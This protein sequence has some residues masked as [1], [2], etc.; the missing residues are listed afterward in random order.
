MVPD[1]DV[2]YV[3]R[4]DPATIAVDALAGRIFEGKVAR[5]A[6]SETELKLMRT[7][8]DLPNPRERASR[9]HVRHGAT[10]SRAPLE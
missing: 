4:G 5:F 3:D 2:P 7:E 10:R 6:N 8:V 1:L 9:R